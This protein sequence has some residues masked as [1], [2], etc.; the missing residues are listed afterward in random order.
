M[1]IKGIIAQCLRL[2]LS[3]RLSGIGHPVIH[4]SHEISILN[5]VAGPVNF[6][7]PSGI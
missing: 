1:A 6:V 7:L 3:D 2:V 4:F 5:N